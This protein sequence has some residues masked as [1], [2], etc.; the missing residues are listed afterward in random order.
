MKKYSAIIYFSLLY[1]QI[2]TGQAVVD[3]MTAVLS[4]ENS[5]SS[6]RQT[7]YYSHG[8]SRTF[9]LEM[10]STGKGK[11]VLMRYVKPTSIKGQSFLLLNNGDDIWTYF[12]RTRR[13]RKL[14]SHAKKQKVQGSDFS[15]EDFGSED[16]W[17]KDY[18]AEN[19]GAEKMEG[20]ECWKLVAQARPQVETDFPKVLL[21]VDRSNYYPVR[22][23]YFDD[24]NQLEKSLYFTN[25]A[26][27]DGYP[28]AKIMI[29]ENHL[30]RTKTIMEILSV[31]YKWI[32]PQGFFSERNLKK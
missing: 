1:G 31:D 4:P 2:P 10:Y 22:M 24:K 13:V 21:Y 27:V 32:P 26:T 29:M 3:S 19:L 12:P 17:G 18:S 28:T 5:K 16:M 30:S 9:E 15:F 14:A 11:K 8:K 7:N 23:D 20:I 6:I 25:I